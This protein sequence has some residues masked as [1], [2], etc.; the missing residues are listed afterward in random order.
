MGRSLDTA[1]VNMKHRVP[2]HLGSQS[3]HDRRKRSSHALGNVENNSQGRRLNFHGEKFS[4]EGGGRDFF[5]F[6]AFL[7]VG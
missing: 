4:F 5:R 1:T 2:R 7:G 6:R 3:F